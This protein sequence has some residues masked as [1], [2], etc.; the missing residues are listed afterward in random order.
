MHW[1]TLRSL[2]GSLARLLAR[3]IVISFVAG[4]IARLLLR[5]FFSSTACSGQIIF[6]RQIKPALQ[7]WCFPENCRTIKNAKSPGLCRDNQEDRTIFYCIP[8]VPRIE[9]HCSSKYWKISTWRILFRC[10]SCRISLKKPMFWTKFRLQ[11]LFTLLFL[12]KSRPA[13]EHI[14]IH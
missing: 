4:S 8:L 13:A 7:Y 12:R 11:L 6:M 2:V 9:S 14:R 1:D 3:T 10:I 5:F